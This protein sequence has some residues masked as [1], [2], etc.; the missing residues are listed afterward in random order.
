MEKLADPDPELE[1]L[2]PDDHVISLR[3]NTRI[4]NQKPRK[5]L[6]TLEKPEQVKILLTQVIQM[7]PKPNE[8]DDEDETTI[9]N[10]KMPKDPRKGKMRE[11]ND[12]SQS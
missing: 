8:K 11:K 1:K 6:Q 5:G 9:R 3:K 12:Q 7:T 4:S 2:P 10:P